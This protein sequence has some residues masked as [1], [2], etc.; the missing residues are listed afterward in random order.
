MSH[1]FISYVRDDL[2]IVDRLVG[3]LKSAGIE[4][5]LDREKIRPGFRWQEAIEKAIEDGAF[6]IAC[7][8]A[9]YR[10][11]SR[12]HMNEE[13]TIAI[14]ELRLRP[15]DRAWFIPVVLNNSTVPKRRIGGGDKLTDLQW[16]DLDNDWNE[17]I[18]KLVSV[19]LDE[20][21]S[22]GSEVKPDLIERARAWK[23]AERLTD[24]LLDPTSLE[25]D[26][27]YAAKELKS[28][29]FKPP[30]V[31]SAFRK[32]LDDDDEMVRKI[33]IEGLAAMGPIAANVLV[34]ALINKDQKVRDIALS[35]LKDR[36]TEL[37]DIIPDLI[38]AFE[39][40]PET[41]NKISVSDVLAAT[42]TF[43]IPALLDA[44]KGQNKFI[45][46][47]AANALSKMSSAVVPSAPE[48]FDALNHENHDV[49]AAAVRVIS[50]LLNKV[51]DID[52]QKVIVSLAY[53][54]KDKDTR[55][56]AYAAL[57]SIG[58]KAFAAVP[59]LIE[60]LRMP[61]DDFRSTWN[62]HIIA[63]KVFV[64]I[65]SSAIPA[66][67]ELIQDRFNP[68]DGEESEQLEGWYQSYKTRYAAVEALGMIHSENPE[69]PP[70]DILLELV[71]DSQENHWIR[72]EAAIIL[73]YQGVKTSA[74]RKIL[75]VS[76]KEDISWDY[77][78]QRA[79]ITL[80]EFSEAADEIVPE[81]IEC[82]QSGFGKEGYGYMESACV[83]IGKL[84]IKAE[85]AKPALTEA[86]KHESSVVQ[87]AA[88]KAL[89]RIDP[90]PESM[91]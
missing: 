62:N 34:K 31:L 13:L 89:E 28:I 69:L 33:A 83:A 84:G 15:T 78:S 7:F 74:I 71:K 57:R 21:L 29:S 9:A 6:F 22:N 91:S 90:K 64:G 5:W 2:E 86:L 3:E 82:L 46:K 27:R 43:A 80:G 49:R 20:S 88:R 65:G 41:S 79:T 52:I 23:R 14:E 50:V 58:D 24:Q 60:I 4:V 32:A 30:I 17:G 54:I 42:G 48:V 81:L 26:R 38:D 12:N 47:G 76:M 53:A 70:S 68:D 66:L 75:I 39:F 8:S 36:G 1:V 85:S 45:I 16:V 25:A 10:Q 37:S 59:A 67:V 72:C 56:D 73:T 61:V 40:V 19:I 55:L 18:G 51:E 44:M 87:S 35:S 63:K 77:L 11:R